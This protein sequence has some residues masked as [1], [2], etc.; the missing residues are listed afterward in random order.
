MFVDSEYHLWISHWDYAATTDPIIPI[1][2]NASKSPHSLNCIAQRIDNK[3]NTDSPLYD[4]QNHDWQNVRDVLIRLANYSESIHS[5]SIESLINRLLKSEDIIELIEHLLQEE[6]DASTEFVG[7]FVREV[8]EACLHFF[9]FINHFYFHHK[10]VKSN[11]FSF[12]W[13]GGISPLILGLVGKFIRKSNRECYK[14]WNIA[15]RREYG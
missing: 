14:A 10:M 1:S 5:Q 3:K 13:G 6:Y 2:P 11:R 15:T 4:Q 9:F 7:G 8:G 12:F